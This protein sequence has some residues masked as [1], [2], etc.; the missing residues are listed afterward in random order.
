[1]TNWMYSYAW[2]TVFSL[3]MSFVFYGQK[4]LVYT[5]ANAPRPTL[6]RIEKDPERVDAPPKLGQKRHREPGPIAQGM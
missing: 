1:M 6:G 2:T 5:T 3:M 4:E